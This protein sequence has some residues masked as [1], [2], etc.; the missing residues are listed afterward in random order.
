MIMN[1]KIDSA[2][3]KDLSI[4]ILGVGM[5]A[6]SIQIFILPNGLSTNGFAGLAVLINFVFNFPPSATFLLIN[7]PIFLVGWKILNRRELLLSIPGAL[8]VSGWLFLF[9]I[10]GVVG[11][12]LSHP[13]IAAIADGFLSGS[14]AGLVILSCGTSGGSVL[15]T[16]IIEAGGKHNFDRIHFILDAL[17][18]TLALLSYLT[19]SKFVF[20]LISCFIFSKMARFIGRSD[21]RANILKRIKI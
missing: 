21:Y 12:E 18:L 5:I 20:T 17:V 1:V 2:F 7:L 3:L 16:R 15:L 8:A 14:G 13:L 9:E 4:L 6:L 10:L 11:F 19:F